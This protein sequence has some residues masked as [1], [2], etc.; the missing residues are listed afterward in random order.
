V[1]IN[2]IVAEHAIETTGKSAEISRNRCRGRKNR[3]RHN[4][5]AVMVRQTLLSYRKVYCQNLRE[6]TILLAK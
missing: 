3:G 5:F 4:P 2:V 1:P 6:A